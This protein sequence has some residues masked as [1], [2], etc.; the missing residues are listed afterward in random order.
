MIVRKENIDFDTH[1]MCAIGECVQGEHEPDRSNT[2][3]PRT[4]DC[5]YLR[6]SSREHLRARSSPGARIKLIRYRAVSRIPNPNPKAA[7]S[8]PLRLFTSFGLGLGIRGLSLALFFWFG[9]G[10]G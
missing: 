2:N 8:L 9:L 5:F 6:P 3:A 1:C 10:L 4:L 7:N